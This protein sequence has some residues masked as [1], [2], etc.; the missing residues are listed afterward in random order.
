[1]TDI[2]GNL[3]A[4]RVHAANIHDTKSGTLTFH[5]AQRYYPTIRSVCADAGY[6]GTFK[7]TLSRFYDVSVDISKCIKPAFKVLPK[8]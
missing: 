4:V 3:L 6:R 7:D 1:V 2:M 5:K 8:R